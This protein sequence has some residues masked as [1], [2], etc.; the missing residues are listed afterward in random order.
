M[1][2]YFLT[3][4]GNHFMISDVVTSLNK[5]FHNFVTQ[6]PEPPCLTLVVLTHEFGNKGFESYGIN[7]P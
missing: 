1:Y 6:P 5:S 3:G 4:G 2:I 7:K